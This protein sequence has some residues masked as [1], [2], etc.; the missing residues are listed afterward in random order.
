VAV[1]GLTSSP[2]I[3]SALGVLGY[4]SAFIAIFN[5]VPVGNLDGVKAW[6]LIPMLL[7]RAL[8]AHLR[9]TAQPPTRQRGN[10][11]TH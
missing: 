9:R 2:E 3:N 7:G 5:L 4:F 10:K 6:P 8:G 1:F 11:W